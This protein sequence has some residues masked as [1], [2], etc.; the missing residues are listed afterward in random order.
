[1]SG[2]YVIPQVYKKKGNITAR[3]NAFDMQNSFY[4]G[5]GAAVGFIAENHMK[6][7]VIVVSNDTDA[8]FHCLIAANKRQR[9]NNKFSNE[10]WLEIL[11]TSKSSGNIFF[12]FVD[13]LFF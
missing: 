3:E 5:E 10:F 7:N 13:L 4:E 11:Y 8:L 2:G 12:L 6:Q 9:V 1:M